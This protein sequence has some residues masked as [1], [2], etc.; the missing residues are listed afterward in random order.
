MKTAKQIT[1]EMIRIESRISK[2]QDILKSI[3]PD[4][5]QAIMLGIELDT[6]SGKINGLNSELDSFCNVFNLNPKS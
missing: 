5:D 4:I 6:L 1:L 2:I 3:D